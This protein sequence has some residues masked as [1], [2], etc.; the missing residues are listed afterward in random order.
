MDWFYLLYTYSKTQKS[1]PC[2]FCKE[3]SRFLPRWHRGGGRCQSWGR[4]LLVYK[5]PVLV[6]PITMLKTLLYSCP[7][8]SSTKNSA[9]VWVTFSLGCYGCAA[10][11]VTWLLCSWLAAW[12]RDLGVLAWGRGKCHRTKADASSTSSP[13]IFTVIKSETAWTLVFG[14]ECLF[15]LQHF[16][17]ALSPEIPQRALRSSLSFHCCD[18]SSDMDGCIS[19]YS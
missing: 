18:F 16:A 14:H 7:E 13:A 12:Q 6:S 15:P 1:S 2:E 9:H 19:M 17:S 10:S 11:L 3:C 8:L 5:L 4:G